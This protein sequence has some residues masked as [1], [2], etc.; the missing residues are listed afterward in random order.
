[1]KKPSRLSDAF[2]A[3]SLKVSELR[4][5][6]LFETAQDGILILDANSGLIV[7]VNPFLTDMLGY[8]CEELV[9]KKLWEVGAFKDVEASQNY[10]VEL[11]KNNYVRYENLPL[12]AKDGHM[13]QV[14]FVSNVYQ[15]GDE[16]VIQCNIR[17]ITKRKH[18]E[19]ALKQ[20]ETI[21]RRLVDHLPAVVYLNAVGETDSTIFVSPQI[22]RLLGYT[23]DEWLA[24]PE[25]WSTRLHPED[26]QKILTQ[27][28]ATNQ[29]N[30]PLDREY[31][32]IARDGNIVWVHDQ[33]IQVNDPVDPRQ[34]RRQGFL[35]DITERKQS[36]ERI[37]RQ[38]EHLTTLSAIDRIIAANFDLRHSLS[39]ILE[40]VASELGVDAAD[41][42]IFNSTLNVLEYG[43]N[44]GFRASSVDNMQVRL[45]DSFAGRAVLERQLVHIQNLKD[46][47][48]KSFL[49]NRLAGEDFACYFGVPLVVKG[50]VKGVLEIFHRAALEPDEEWFAFLTALSGQAAI[51]IETTTLFESLQRS[52]LE[53]S[54]AYDATIE[55]WSR[56]LDLRDKE[57]EGHTQ[58]VTEMA[59]KLSRT[60]GLNDWEQLQ[61]RWGS[62]LHDIGKMGIPDGILLKPGPLTDEEWIIMRKH[63]VFAYD[64]IAPIRY[65]RQALEIPYHH[66]EKWD[67]SGYPLG[68]KGEQIPLAARIFSVVDV[69]DALS[70]D[71]PYRAGWK[72]GEVRDHLRASSGTHFDPQVVAAFIQ[73]MNY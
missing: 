44:R 62:L 56:A 23:P 54:L 8:S 16:K 52:N 37:R 73:I 11:Q 51:A 7:D 18:M 25:L 13:I 29:N 39:E 21:F 66:H 31:R 60:F 50:Q 35:I 40:H 42:L 32:M 61:V 55:G 48:G 30:E 69:W 58:R 53:L 57:T 34:I 70:S 67:G 3:T 47:P 27:T 17:D 5:R 49:S 43:A 36:E 68:L 14:E 71:R 33:V 63:P 72:E 38:L 65:L 6:R 10:F 28:A 45:E 9:Q 1:L 2:N 59:V 41:F 4:Y 15:V 20:S 19:D 12:K 26:R 64:M 46:V 24:N 22:Y